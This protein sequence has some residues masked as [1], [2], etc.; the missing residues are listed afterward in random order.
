[1]FFG[2]KNFVRLENPEIRVQVASLGQNTH[3]SFWRIQK[4]LSESSFIYENWFSAEIHHFQLEVTISAENRF[5]QIKID[6]NE[7]FWILQNKKCVLWPGEATWTGN[8]WIFEPDEIF[9]PEKPLFYN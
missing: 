6:S 2:D 8:F 4:I 3:F 1:M 9:I 7:I 5:S